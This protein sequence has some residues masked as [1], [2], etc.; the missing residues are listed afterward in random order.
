MFVYFL[1]KDA[2]RELDHQ[3]YIVLHQATIEKQKLEQQKQKLKLLFKQKK[4]E[5]NEFEQNIHGKSIISFHLYFDHYSLV[6]IDIW[7]N[8]NATN[9]DIYKSTPINLY[10]TSNYIESISSLQ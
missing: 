8:A 6:I 4:I 3:Q 2:L 5:A 9:H 7:T 10:S 1:F